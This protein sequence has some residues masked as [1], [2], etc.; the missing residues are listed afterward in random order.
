M[1]P[2][3]P[4]KQMQSARTFLRWV[5]VTGMAALAALASPAARADSVAVTARID[6]SYANLNRDGGD[7]QIW[8]GMARGN[9][10]IAPGFN[11]EIK[12]GDDRIDLPASVGQS[13]NLWNYGGDFYWRDRA[14][15]FG[16]SIEQD[17]IESVHAER[18]QPSAPRR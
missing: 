16:A 13:S 6:A 15:D 2:H 4:L 9:F 14:G 1:L 17:R 12:G 3:L 18:I 11:V 10:M 7:R 5:P 8:A